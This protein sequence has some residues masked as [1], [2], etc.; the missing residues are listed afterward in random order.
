[1]PAFGTKAAAMSD[2]D[3]P[4]LERPQRRLLR[5]IFNG[6]TVPIVADDRSFLTYKD[7]TRYLLSLPPETRDAAYL[8]IR[9]AAAS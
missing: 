6:R 7:A 5:R 8:A 4:G 1:M 3:E 2:D 9:A